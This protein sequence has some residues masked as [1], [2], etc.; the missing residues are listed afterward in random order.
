M[1]LLEALSGFVFSL[2]VV[3]IGGSVYVTVWTEACVQRSKSNICKS[4][5]EFVLITRVH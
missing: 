2:A 4:Y 1:V 5:L 3:L